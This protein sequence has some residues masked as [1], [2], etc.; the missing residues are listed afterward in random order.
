MEAAAVWLLE[1][2]RDGPLV[3]LDEEDGPGL[4]HAGE[5]E[6][7]VEIALG[8]GAV[9]REPHGRCLFVAELEGHA[10]PSRVQQLAGDGDGHGE[11]PRP[12]WEDAATL[13]ALPEGVDEVG[14]DPP[15]HHDPLFAEGGDEPVLRPHGHGDARL[16]RLLAADGAVGPHASLPL[17]VEGLLVEL[18]DADHGPV[19]LLELAVRQVRHEGRV[20]LAVL[21][22]DL[23]AQGR[24]LVDGCLRHPVSPLGRSGCFSRHLP[25]SNKQGP[26]LEGKKGEK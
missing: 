18:A 1:G 2:D 6:G 23:Q 11:A 5:V 26:C 8:G 10:D 24:G 19:E 20:H 3:V 12:L 14:R 22:Q 13:V 16:C 7:L 21:V 4:E 25:E 17:Q 15:E 9:A